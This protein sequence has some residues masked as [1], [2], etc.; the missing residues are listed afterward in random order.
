MAL[1][2]TQS[3]TEVVSGNLLWGG[4][5]VRERPTPEADN[6]AALSRLSRNFWNLDVSEP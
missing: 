3:L 4:G 5:G 1:G 2:L 6:F